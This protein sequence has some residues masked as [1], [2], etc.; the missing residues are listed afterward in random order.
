MIQ[1]SVVGVNTELFSLA[2]R[3]SYHQQVIGL[4]CWQREKSVKALPAG[5]AE[6]IPDGWHQDDLYGNKAILQNDI[7]RKRHR[8]C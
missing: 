4:D 5:N 6:G 3:L 2:R 1:E 8:F 7:L